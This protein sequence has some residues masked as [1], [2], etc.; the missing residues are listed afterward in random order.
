MSEGQTV[1]PQDAR[2]FVA[3]FVHDPKVLEGM[4]DEQVVAYHG[5]VTEGLTK[6]GPK[7][8]PF[9]EGWRKAMAGDDEKE[10]KQA[11]RYASPA[12]V[13]KKARALEQRMTSGE[14][15]SN[16]AKDAN[17]DQVKAWRAENGIPETHEKYTIKLKDGSSPD[18]A[19]KPILAGFLKAAHGVNLNND[20]ASSVAEWY[21]AEQERLTEERHT[22]DQELGKKA[23]DELR[24]KWGADYRRNDTMISNFLETVPASVKEQFMTGRLG[25]GTPIMASVPV[26]EWLAQMAREMNPAGTVVPNAGA[27][28]GAA[29][30]DEIGAL[31]K[32]S[33]D[34][35]SSY[36]KGPMDTNGE[37]KEMRR[38]REL[39][40]AKAQM[41][42]KAA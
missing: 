10:L 9:G 6:H 1:T 23:E 26:K 36:W 21:Y 11:E 42:R 12:E 33:G 22:Q 5:R 16:L 18:P 2:T 29:I 41:A 24:V 39:N 30:E 34:R 4:K 15:K 27:N 13:W 14:L 25:D 40:D 7:H 20:Q 28:M 8:V 31:V 32:L 3:D 37:T 38:L 35:S 17:A 19:D